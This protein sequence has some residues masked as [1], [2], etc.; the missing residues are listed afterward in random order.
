MCLEKIVSE[1]F[2]LDILVPKTGF[3]RAHVGVSEL[4]C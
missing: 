3:E 1:R 2:S 4:N